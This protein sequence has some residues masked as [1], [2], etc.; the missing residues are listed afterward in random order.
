VKRREFITL[1]GGTAAAWPLAARAQQAR[2]VVRIGVLGPSLS[3]AFP[4]TLYQ[5]FSNDRV[6]PKPV[7]QSVKL[8][9]CETRSY[10]LMRSRLFWLVLRRSRGAVLP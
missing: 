4:S 10:T 1:L 2:T 8:G 7:M 5:A 6:C 9:L 3:N